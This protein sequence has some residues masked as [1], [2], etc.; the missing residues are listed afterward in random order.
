M[1]EEKRPSLN[2]WPIAAAVLGVS[3]LMSYFMLFAR[4]EMLRDT[5]ALNLALVGCGMI[6]GAWG[7]IVARRRG[8]LLRVLGAGVGLALATLSAGLLGAYVFSLSSQL[9]APEQAT[10]ELGELPDLA[11]LDHEG[12]E[13][14]LSSLRGTR[15][16]LVF[17]RGYW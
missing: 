11:L 3:G 12:S 9:P 1:T 17:Y 8:G 6:A 13:L 2:L 16:L 5:A 15:V 4:F 7:F 10:L 14:S